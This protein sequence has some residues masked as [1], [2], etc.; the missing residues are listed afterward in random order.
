MQEP[1]PRGPTEDQFPRAYRIWFLALAVLISTFSVIDRTA[2][3][4]LGGAIKQDLK[5]SDM[6]FGLIS[7]VGFALFYAILGL[8][9]TRLAD[10][11]SRVRLIS[12]AVGVF[13]V[14]AALCG[15]ARGF[16][17]LLLCRVI[18]GVG[19]AGVAR[20]GSS[21]LGPACHAASAIGL[22]G[23]MSVMSCLYVWAAVHFALAARTIRRDLQPA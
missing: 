17:Q 9:L 10:T 15:F 19:E 6:Q 3:I 20:A 5:L 2:L 12:I 23:A 7:G 11:R 21:P 8:P 13:S 18:V 16:V 4:T 1:S 22:S 14:F